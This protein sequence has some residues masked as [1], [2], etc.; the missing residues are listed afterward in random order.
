MSERL[1]SSFIL[2][3]L[4]IFDGLLQEV[5]VDFHHA[6]RQVVILL[7]VLSVFAVSELWRAQVP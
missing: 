1:D 7:V 6:H 5:L 2:Q 3:F 4:C